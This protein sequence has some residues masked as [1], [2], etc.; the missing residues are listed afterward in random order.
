MISP[1]R[2]RI[3]D[4]LEIAYSRV[5]GNTPGIMFLC[6]H[7]SDMN[8]SKALFLE[9]WAKRNGC[10]FLRFDYSGHGRS[11][12]TLLETNISDWTRDAIAMIDHLCAGKQIL[13]GSS[14]GGWL[15]LNVALARPDRI[16]GLIGISAAPDFT[17]DLIWQKLGSKEQADFVK[18]GQITEANPYADDPIIYPYHL[19]EDGRQHLRLLGPLAIHQPVRLLH[20]MA[21]VEVPWQTAIALAECLDAE[22]VTVHLDKKATHRFS[23]PEQLALLQTVLENL[24]KR[25]GKR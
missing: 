15:M 17:E 14:L 20:G 4:S 12:G 13:I 25:V 9:S 11:D 16:A 24:L 2:Y 22:D 23:E 8:G 6:G 7:G 21:D 5:E 19:I 10:A 18:E 1:S 3:N